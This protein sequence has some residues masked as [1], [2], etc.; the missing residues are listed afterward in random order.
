VHTGEIELRDGA[1]GG[2]SVDI[3]AAIARLA[4]PGE[5]LVSRTVTDLV[6][7]SGISF[8]DRGTHGLSGMPDGWALFAVT[9]V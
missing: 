5:I 3:A 1:I 2:G 6:I 8:A 7:G 4:R 9:A